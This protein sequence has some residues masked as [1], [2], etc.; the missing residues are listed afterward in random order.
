MLLKMVNLLKLP[1][2]QMAE[3]LS[4]A[5][6]PSIIFHDPSTGRVLDVSTE[7]EDRSGFM[8]R[9]FTFLESPSC[10][11]CGACG[12]WWVWQQQDGVQAVPPHQGGSAEEGLC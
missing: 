10:S 3:E 4:E 5:R 7:S 6:Y 8:V 12:V 11:T 9:A 2:S 1:K